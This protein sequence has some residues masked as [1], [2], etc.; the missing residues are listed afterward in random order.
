MSLVVDASAATALC[1]SERGFELAGDELIAPALLRSEVL[2]ALTGL[3]WRKEITR[4]LADIATTRLLDGPIRLVSRK[5]IYTEAKRIARR[6][7]WAKTYDAEY[8]AL[9]LL[10]SRPLLTLDGRLA[11]RV[12]SIVQV[13]TPADL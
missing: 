11:R 7:G 2:S 13:R 6:L 1:L 10:E 8:A 4:D 3:E 9:A 12:E 5:S